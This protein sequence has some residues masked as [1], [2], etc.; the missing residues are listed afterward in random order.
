[1]SK[2][3]RKIKILFA[4]NCMN[5]GGAPSVVFHQMKLLDKERFEP[6]LLTLYPSKPANFLAEM[7]FVPEAHQHHFRL[8]KR[9]IFDF[10]TL[11]AIYRML[12][13]ER[14]DVVYTHLFLANFLVRAMAIVA[15]VPHMV[16]FEHSTYFNKSSWQIAMDRLLARFTDK[17]IVSTNEVR[18]FTALQEG[19]PQERFAVIR[20][21]VVVPDRADVDLAAL[22]KEMGV[23]GRSRI[24][25]V[26]VGRFSEE[27]GQLILLEAVTR[28]VAKY[29]EAFFVLVGHGP[30]EQ[31]MRAYVLEHDLEQNVRIVHAPNRA[32]EYL[33][34]ADWF[35][36]P[37]TR[38]GQ[39]IVVEEAL[40]AGVPVIAA[41]LTGMGEVIQDG[42][43][44]F[45]FES[46]NVDALAV[47][48]GRAIEENPGRSGM[49]FEARNTA[50]KLFSSEKRIEEL[51]SLFF[52]IMN[53]FN[54]L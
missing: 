41:R 35:V 30:L 22:W 12:K 52:G 38:E 51:E 31:A 6:H 1:M 42:K 4:I 17:I 2:T 18:E 32:K 16:A 15:R 33:Y 48:I 36:L 47:C 23:D 54:N 7:S 5:I 19:L 53:K 43:N 10:R 45:L 28:V 40:T 34:L 3:G 49:S 27:K 21:P 39:A 11:Y 9:S 29:P 37:S 8:K 13:R 25:F 46:G 26:T 14:F 20:N 24:T 50:E 44:G